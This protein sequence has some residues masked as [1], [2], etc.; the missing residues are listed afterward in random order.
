MDSNGCWTLTQMLNNSYVHI[1]FVRIGRMKKL[2][3]NG[4]EN[5]SVR[6][7]RVMDSAV[8]FKSSSVAAK[9]RPICKCDVKF[10]K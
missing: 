8:G 4:N 3:N 1:R 5:I 7:L 6:F 10:R 2:P 9:E